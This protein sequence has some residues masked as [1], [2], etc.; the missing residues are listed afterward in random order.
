MEQNNDLELDLDLTKIFKFLKDKSKTLILSMLLGGLLGFVI[1]AFFITPKYT[2]FVDL[3]VTNNTSTDSA[4]NIND[5]TAS[6]KLVSTYIV[7]LQ[8]NSITDEVM[9]IMNVDMTK[10]EF[11]DMIEFTS[12]NNTEVLRI[13]VETEDPQLSVNICKAYVK[14]AP[15]ILGDIVG[16]G[17]VKIISWPKYAESPSFPNIPLFTI[18]GATLAL[19][20]SVA[21]NIIIMLTNTK[22]SDEKNLSEKYS[23]P[24]LGAIPDFF[25]FYKQLNISKKD[26]KENDKLKKKNVD[27]K[28]IVTQAT[29]LSEKT[30]FQIT[31]AYAAIRTNILFLL[32]NMK[33]GVIVVTS[34]NANDLKTTTTMNLAIS[35]GQIGAKVLL[36]DADLRNPSIY[37]YFKVSNKF[38]LSRVVAGFDK[39]SDVVFKKIVPG[40]DFLP[41]GPLPP[42][43]AGLLGSTNMSQFIKRCSAYYDFV[44]IDTSP[45]NIVSDSLVIASEASGI[46]VTVRENKTRYPEVDR[47][48]KLINMA[49]ANMLGFILTDVD[50]S[51]SSYY[52]DYGKYGYG[53]GNSQESM[54]KNQ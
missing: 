14:V 25:K 10:D 50:M 53:Y 18:F 48:I 35:M 20:A 44:L 39:F 40:V 5:I 52:G 29:V 46:I 37:R 6:Q 34:P 31:E 36:I 24:V 51:G 32:S 54:P 42:N 41:A 13:S 49:H 4:L 38:G 23:F 3:Y 33:N 8:T 22:I 2:S 43:P 26:L 16:A 28:K 21:I 27:N 12:V 30:P 7:M 15:D 17:T 9:K 47:A 45:I 19:L 11:L 1:S